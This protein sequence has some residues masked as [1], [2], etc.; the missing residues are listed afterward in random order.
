MTTLGTRFQKAANWSQRL[1]I[2]REIMAEVRA[3]RVTEP[4]TNKLIQIEEKKDG[5]LTNRIVETA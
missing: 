5:I 4:C 2:A 1:P 3:E